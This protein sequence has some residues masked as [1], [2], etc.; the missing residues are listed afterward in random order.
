M[1]ISFAPDFG[2]LGQGCTDRGNYRVDKLG[3]AVLN[4]MFRKM[5][6]RSRRLSIPEPNRPTWRV[7]HGE[8]KIKTASINEVLDNSRIAE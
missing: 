2:A 7:S 8:N 6:Q 1:C 3:V 4:G 5:R